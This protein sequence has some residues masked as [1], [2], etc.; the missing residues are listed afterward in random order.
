MQELPVQ[1]VND[2]P[3]W[4]QVAYGDIDDKITTYG[5]G[6]TSIAMVLKALGKDVAPNQLRTQCKGHGYNE[7]GGTDKGNLFPYISKTYNVSVEKIT[8]FEKCCE[9]A[10]QGYPIVLDGRKDPG[11]T[12]HKRC[13][14]TCYGP[15]G[16]YVVL[17]AMSGND[18]VIND[19]RGV[20]SSGIRPRSHASDGFICGFKIGDKK[21]N[22]DSSKFKKL[23]SED[24]AEPGNNGNTGDDSGNNT[25][26]ED[27][28][29]GN[30]GNG[31]GNSITVI[32][33]NTTTV[34]ESLPNAN[35]S[36]NW[37]DMHK[38][39]GIT[40]HMYP[41][42]HDCTADSM[43]KY[44]ESL[45][46]DRNFHYKVDKD[47]KIDFN[48]KPASGQT[49]GGNI[50]GSSL[51]DF[52]VKPKD[53][54]NQ[55]VIINGEN[56]TVNNGN[57]GGGNNDST[58][59]STP[60][61]GKETE[62]IDKING[63]DIP[64]K[65]YNYCISQG[66]SVAAACGI[67]GNAE[68]ESSF[69]PKNVNRLG[70]TGL[71][72]LL[73][74]RA[75]ALK[76]YAK[77]AGK[78]WSDP[79]IQIQYM[80]IEWSGDSYIDHLRKS[81]YNMTLDSWKKITDPKQA[82]KIF[83][84]VFERA[85]DGADG[86]G[87]RGK[88]AQKWYDKFSNSSGSKRIR[89][90]TFST[91][92][93]MSDDQERVS[94]Y[95]NDY[96][97]Y[98]NDEITVQQQ[99]EPFGWPAPMQTHIQS[100]FGYRTDT[101]GYNYHP[102]I[103]IANYTGSGAFC[104]ADGVV[105]KVLA[106][107][108]LKGYVRIDHGNKVQ[109]VYGSLDEI[110]VKEGDT[111]TKGQCIGTTDV[112]VSN[113]LMHLHFEI[114]IDGKHVDPLDY[115]KPGGGYK[116]NPFPQVETAMFALTRAVSTNT[117]NTNKTV[118][119]TTDKKVITW[120]KVDK[121]KICFASADNN[122]H[123][124]I[125]ANLFNNQHPKY[126]LS[127]GEFFYDEYDLVEKTGNVDYPKTEKKLIEQCAKAL[128]D[129]GFTSKQL[130]REF[131]L[132]RAPSPFLYL[133]KDKWIA[134][135]KEVDK[136]VSWL[137]KKYGKVTSTYIP[138]NLLTNQNTN[139]FIETAPLPN[140]VI[141]PGNN[142]N[143]DNN[144][145]NDNS[146]PADIKNALFIGD[147]WGVGI[148]KLVEADGGASEAN[149]GKSFLYYYNG[150]TD[151]LKA[152]KKDPS[153]IYIYL[154]LND[155]KT[156][157]EHDYVNNFYKR[158]KQLWPNTKVYIGK[159]IHAGT[160]W[161]NNKYN[162]YGN[163][164]DWNKA[165][166]KF[167][168]KLSGIC[169]SNGFKLIDVSAGLIDSKGYLDSSLAT[170]DGIHLKDWKKYY[171]NIKNAIGEFQP[172]SND[173]QKGSGNFIWPLPGSTR[174]SSNFGPRKAPTPGASTY[175][176]GLDIPASKGT[177]VIAADSGKVV[178][179]KTGYNGGRGNY[180]VIDHGNGIGTLYQHL[181]KYIVT[182]GQSVKQGD[183]IA[184][185][186]NSG[187]GTGPHLHFEVHKDFSGTKGTPVNP[188]N[189]VSPN[190]KK[191]NPD[192]HISA[193][194]NTKSVTAAATFATRERAINAIATVDNDDNDIEEIYPTQYPGLFIGDNWE[195]EMRDLIVGDSNE[196]EENYFVSGTGETYSICEAAISKDSSY[197]YNPTKN[198]DRLEGMNKDV[199]FVYIHLGYNRLKENLESND[200]VRFLNKVKELY[201]NVPVY[202][203]KL[204][205]C[206]KRYSGQDYKSA[207][208]FNEALD[209]YNN[210]LKSYCIKNGFYF[211]DISKD[212][213][214]S[215]GYLK[216]SIVNSDGI[217]LNN[218]TTYYNNIKS[219][220]ES[221]TNVTMVTEIFMAG[222]IDHYD[223]P[224]EESHAST[225][226]MR[227]PKAK[228]DKQY[229]YVGNT[230]GTEMKKNAKEKA[231]TVAKL[232]VG[233]ELEI[234]GEKNTYYK[235]K[236]NKKTGY[237]LKEDVVIIG[238]NHGEVS[239]SY[240]GQTCW[241]K[242]ENTDY[243][244]DTKLTKQNKDLSEQTKAVIIGTD[245]KLGLYKI[246]TNDTSG[247]VKAYA[248]TF[249]NSDFKVSNGKDPGD[250]VIK[251][252]NGE[253]ENNNSSG[254][255]DLVSLKNA[256]FEE[257][258]ISMWSK[259]GSIEFSRIVNPEWG[260]KGHWPYRKTGFARIK[261]ASSK[262][263]G[264]SQNFDAGDSK[265]YLRVLFYIKQVTQ[266]DEN[267]GPL[268]PDKLKQ[269]NIS[270]K[271][272]DKSDKIKYE[273]EVDISGI[274]NTIWTRIGCIFSGLED[275]SYKLFIGSKNKF[276]L[277]IDDITIEKIYKNNIDNTIG[278]SNSTSGITLSGLGTTSID[279]GGV[280]IYKVAKPT[281]TNATQPDI[282]T[283][284]TQKEYEEIMTYSTAANIDIYTNSFEPYDKDLVEVKTVG[285]NSD[286][287][288]EVLTEK[289]YTFTDNMIRY[290]VVETGPGSIDHCVK[291]VDELSVLYKNMDCKVD[292]IYPDL[293]IP[294]KYTTSTYDSMS[295]NS[296]PLSTV[297]DAT[298]SLEDALDKSYSYDYKLLDKKT[299]KSSGKPINYMDPYPYDDK[300]TDL[301]NHY[302]KVLIDEI[303][304][305]VYSCNHP[306]CP[307]AHPMAK[308]FAML[309]DMAI[310]QSKMTEQ[311]LVRIENILSTVTRY[312]GRMASRVNINCVYY[313]GQSVMGKYKCIRCLR[314]DRV[315]D[316]ATVTMDQCL[317]CTR[318]EPIIGQIYDILDE[319]GFNGSAIL[320]DMQMSY[321]SLDDFKN[322]NDVEKR[323]SRYSYIDTNK[324]EKKK[325]KSLID[326]WQATDK[327]LKEK[328]IKKKYTDKE[329]QAKELDKLLPSD[330]LFMMDWTEESVDLQ[331]PDIKAY[332]TE[333]IAAKYKNQ[334]GDPGEDDVASAEKSTQMGIDKKT[335][336]IIASG[337]WIDTR[338]KDDSVQINKYSSLDFYFENFNLN[339]TGYE[340]DNGIKG[341]IGLTANSTGD[342]NGTGNGNGNSDIDD[343]VNGNG[344]AI[345]EKIT[346]MAKTIVQ[347]YKDGKAKYSNNP[348]T[349]DHDKPQKCSD[350]KIGY[351]C[352]SFVSCCYKAAGLSDFYDGR[353]GQGNAGGN[354]LAQ[355]VIK[356]GGMIWFADKEGMAKA[357]PGDVLMTYGS[358]L[359]D[360][361]KLSLGSGCKASHAIIYMGNGMIAHSSS[362]KYGIKYEKADYYVTGK[363]AGH[364]Y[365]LRPK[366]LINADKSSSK[367]GGSSIDETV[368]K[369]D[370]V[371]YIMA[372]KGSKCTQ[373]KE[374]EGGYNDALGNRL[375]SSRCNT[376]ASHNLPYGTKVYIP[377]FKGRQTANPSCIFTV[378]D[379]G[380]A[381]FDFDI[382][383][384]ASVYY[385]NKRMDVYVVSWGSG[386]GTAA[387]VTYAYKHMAHSESMW[388]DYVRNGGTTYKVTKFCKDDVNI[389]SQSFWTKY[390]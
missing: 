314:D 172:K 127:I 63:N 121:G 36:D 19:P 222:D 220:I 96:G 130:W 308:N 30:Y 380:N 106:G 136:Q 11:T 41:P 166:D 329:E 252:D 295:K 164:D 316:G 170:S 320:D 102:G 351:D 381:G 176:R 125:D 211:I 315:H 188:L 45:G 40:L 231:G 387:S 179:A 217:T 376:V 349:I 173:G 48:K 87:V 92:T 46:W 307:I 226:A 85:E 215:E 12:W 332:P 265:C 248:I 122:T 71:F 236:F 27:N 184:E 189:Y 113:P 101:L 82:A 274:S 282:K 297:E 284:I 302:P 285:L 55:T 42:Y 177:K 347:E 253:E 133:D 116:K 367:H 200:T 157:N 111:V 348:R 64:T 66:C 112:T 382:C 57:I 8:S 278:D 357:L 368:G 239:Q 241:I 79:D 276:D 17:V 191:N 250:E 16:H 237:I 1:T 260:T 153:F 251:P 110:K 194:N 56:V 232:A 371:K 119:N 246:K 84:H 201:N 47:T 149:S 140:G 162:E 224:K 259:M 38:I 175:H 288:L 99:S 365:F 247:Y 148:E 280:M 375:H 86:T 20:F 174:I 44:F 107:T 120:D 39:K 384:P 118:S 98:L 37:V 255:L 228:N 321:M 271:L 76:N 160:A 61:E 67:V 33:N 158:V 49:T 300:I 337:E 266:K 344:A 223:E 249:D 190:G 165:V 377:Y 202:V 279:N 93:A 14:V 15:S 138:N 25:P 124:Y 283:I 22:L 171:D 356:K 90:K 341:N 238:K 4:S 240:V 256:D 114:L 361:N 311:R 150:S 227:A 301:E 183:K 346:E 74:D 9:L 245:I 7:P 324:K 10:R 319:T 142:G 263:S 221:T 268:D 68:T 318:Y 296:I 235:C 108:K 338:E 370:G 131:D 363:H 117:K 339:R 94:A 257:D 234:T 275:S 359:I 272:L 362:T 58:D 254:N 196:L 383:C 310:N 161:A 143:G 294:P 340:Y 230:S 218:Y 156:S 128:Y 336:D 115:V 21:F 305:R 327:K 59:G 264:I 342:N 243:Y 267:S 34:Q 97:T 2:F 358:G 204:P 3:Y 378:T 273:K 343:S 317:T 210:N 303:E 353:T 43:A 26:S 328:E 28:S 139:N 23:G 207:D 109:T 331:R 270:I 385:G 6:P 306:G 182:V 135:C 379:T 312:L 309:N 354:T 62:G 219:I 244:K 65:I 198:I 32:Y 277:Y 326:E 360:K 330:Y 80:W 390:K 261:N 298:I 209:K 5:C 389:T 35:V 104:Y 167:N 352:T 373:Y 206:G 323:S 126:T 24:G 144:N 187:I 287:R 388:R 258:D 163:I 192:S 51:S 213:M 203:A 151:K 186:G 152:M 69:D 333:K 52:E 195:Y 50:V 145:N 78:E 214:D 88:Y 70:A 169:S 262:I 168:E 137:N 229:C 129:E 181:N 350:G 134:F 72:Q 386:K 54:L 123:T 147:S 53:P 197:Y 216:D 193:D 208:A 146:G 185:V 291:P 103:D 205:H 299:K 366:S 81:R 313:G 141:V 225:F 293:V 77:K 105:K 60:E 334:K 132:N 155:L 180:V 31:S 290:K 269:T 372:L 100:Y 18:V 212:L 89:A 355:E 154:G 304:N 91:F 364:S 29:G 199:S 322:L 83:G 369:I 13:L 95:A 286:S 178:V 325:P 374:G 242:F 73:G 281:E 233:D 292:P 289:V 345:R 335:Y 75:T 159:L